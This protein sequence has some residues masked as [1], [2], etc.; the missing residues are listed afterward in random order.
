M[1]GGASTGRFVAAIMLLL[2]FA[3]LPGV[4]EDLARDHAWAKSL[5]ATGV[6]ALIAVGGR[7]RRWPG[8]SDQHTH[9]PR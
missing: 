9:C 8:C 2:L 7:W 1:N 3:S 5:W 4:R 6:L